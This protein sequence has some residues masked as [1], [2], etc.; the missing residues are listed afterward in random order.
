MKQILRLLLA[1][2]LMGGFAFADTALE[3]RPV[4]T[5]KEDIQLLKD[6]EE[7]QRPIEP[8]KVE[9]P[10]VVP[11]KPK[12]GVQEFQFLQEVEKLL[13][14]TTLEGFGFSYGEGA[15]IVLIFDGDPR[16][17]RAF[18]LSRRPRIVID[19]PGLKTKVQGRHPVTHP[20][21]KRLRIWQHPDKTRVVL[22]LRVEVP[23]NIERFEK[24]L[25]IHFGEKL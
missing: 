6:L 22:D 21:V 12:R 8:V 16:P 2:L 9:P 5:Q 17:F 20:I 14:A 11:L 25:I 3:E 1:I 4:E 24:T 18:P 10:V 19:L 15:D 23:P 7:T 13:P